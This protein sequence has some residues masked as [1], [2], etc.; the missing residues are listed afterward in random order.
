M[1]ANFA[2]PGAR[3]ARFCSTHASPDMIQLAGRC[4]NAAGCTR[5]ASFAHAGK[6]AQFCQT[7]ADATMVNVRSREC[8]HAGCTLQPA[9]NFPGKRVGAYCYRHKLADMV[10]VIAPRCECC[11]ITTVKANGNHCLYC[12]I[13]LFPNLPRVCNYKTK[14]KAVADAVRSWF[15]DLDWAFDRVVH[16][17]GSGRR[18]DIRLDMGTYVLIIEVDESQHRTYE[19]I[20]EN[21]RVMQLYVDCGQRDV[22]LVRFNPDSYVNASNCK[23][24][25]C[26][27][28]TPSR[29][30][31]VVKKAKDWEHRLAALKRA[32]HLAFEHGAAGKTV[33]EMRLFYDGDA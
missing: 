4:K 12:S 18:P 1:T 5:Q 19:C 24:P 26:W 29:G 32:L 25:S 16:G 10:N 2:M 7:H 6:T 31:L 11:G 27:G 22:V 14:E 20:C 21:K 8:K 33:H 13:N 15:P 3:R 9:F 30:I 23:V 28:L 17:A